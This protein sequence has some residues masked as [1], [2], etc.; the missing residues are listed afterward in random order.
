MQL[1]RVRE[2]NRESQ[3]GDIELFRHID[4]RQTELRTDKAFPL[5]AIATENENR[6]TE[7]RTDRAFPLVANGTENENKSWEQFLVDFI[8]ILANAYWTIQFWGSPRKKKQIFV[9]IGQISL[10]FYPP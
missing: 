3:R 7:L 1:G 2:N 4:D 8:I 5:V 10:T 6:Q 9:V